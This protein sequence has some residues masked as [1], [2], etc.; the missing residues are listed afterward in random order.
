MN[1]QN[2]I[3]FKPGQSGNP[4]GRPK[5]SRSLATRARKILEEHTMQGIA[6]QIK[7]SIPEDSKIIDALFFALSVH[8]IKG[9]MK[10]AQLLL[11]YA[12]G[13]PVD[14]NELGEF[15]LGEIEGPEEVQEKVI[16]Q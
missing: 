16:E 1:K 6:K 13:K 8:A 5:G 11:E 15:D 4:T 7:I 12:Y 2:L 3:P 9:N 14:S 10:A